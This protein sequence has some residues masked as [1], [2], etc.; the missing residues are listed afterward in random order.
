[1]KVAIIGSQATDSLESNLAEAFSHKGHDIRIFDI[2][3]RK[4]VQNKY[5]IQLDTLLRRFVNR[6]DE[7]LFIGQAKEVIEQCPDLVICTYRF[8]H[9]TFVAM[10]KGHL[11]CP[12]VQLN[13]DALT[14]F[15]LQQVFA[16]PYDVWFTKD[17]Y[18][19]RFMQNNMRLNVRL[20]NEAFS[21]RLHPRPTM[22]K[23]DA[24]RLVKTDVMTYGTIYPYRSQM[25][26]AVLDAGIELKVYGTRPHRF[27]DHRLDTAYQREYITGERKSRLLYGSKVVFNQM[28]YAEIEGVNNRFF[29]VNGSGAFQL[30]DYRPI[31]HDLL[32]IDPELVS[33]RTI[34]EGI[35]KIKHYLAHPEERYTIAEKVYRHF[36]EHYTYDQLVDTIL[37]AI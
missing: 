23:A 37:A 22:S 2:M 6:Y 30:S 20:Y 3:S 35:E 7:H 9:P 12:V 32:P 29:E 13:P 14:T 8:I 33:F 5:G 11:R 36:M 21:P 1:M 10:V 26:G 4:W 31:L 24:E 17:P 16:S 18:I 15:E 27:F 34:D 25:L 28:H 19:Q